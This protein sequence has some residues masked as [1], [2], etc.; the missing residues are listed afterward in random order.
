VRN[1]VRVS[2]CLFVCACIYLA[3]IHVYYVFL[4]CVIACMQPAYVGEPVVCACTCAS[5]SQ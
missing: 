3:R 4:A 1:F 2:V 5:A